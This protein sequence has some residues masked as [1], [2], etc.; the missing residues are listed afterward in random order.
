MGLTMT[1]PAHG[2]VPSDEASAPDKHWD[3]PGVPDGPWFARP[4]WQQ[5]ALLIFVRPFY[6]LRGLVAMGRQAG[7]LA[8]PYFTYGAKRGHARARAHPERLGSKLARLFEPMGWVH[9]LPCAYGWPHHH[10]EVHGPDD[11]CLESYLPPLPH[12][13]VWERDLTLASRLADNFDDRFGRWYT[14][15]GPEDEAGGDKD[16]NAQEPTGED[17]DTLSPKRSN[18]DA[19]LLS[20]A[21]EAPQ[22]SLAGSASAADSTR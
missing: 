4:R 13:I 20:E 11:H 7:A 10:D 12:A 16:Q 18:I 22:G 21:L 6:L 15:I 17:N 9:E 1:E 19:S 5:L 14:L 3:W 8:L 2:V